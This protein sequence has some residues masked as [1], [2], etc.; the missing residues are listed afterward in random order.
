MPTSA[1]L[2]FEDETII[3]LFPG[4]RKGWTLQGSQAMVGITG[5]NARR[6]LFGTINMRTGHRIIARYRNM[7]QDSFQDFLRLVRSKYKGRHVWMLLD[8]AGSHTTIASR[9]LA[10]ALNI[11]L[12]WLPT[13]CPE[14][15][16]M[17]HLW[18][19]M[20][21]DVSSNHQ[22][23]SVDDHATQAEQYLLELS[24]KAALKRAGILSKNF[25][26]RLFLN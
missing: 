25:W 26:L 14:L 12:I 17:D 11:D 3:R 2:L 7:R 15:N 10:M 13:Q 18:R 4:L 6:V 23:E 21:T 24:N 20:K 19:Q 22:Y 8:K 16:A 5:R 9:T 1:V